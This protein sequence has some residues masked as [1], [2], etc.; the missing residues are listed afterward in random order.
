[1]FILIFTGFRFLYVYS[2][3]KIVCIASIQYNGSLY[4]P[5]R[6]KLLTIIASDDFILIRE[7]GSHCAVSLKGR[8]RQWRERGLL[9]LSII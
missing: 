6:D 8:L 1:M 4:N 2:S 7:Y 9:C 5:L 3:F